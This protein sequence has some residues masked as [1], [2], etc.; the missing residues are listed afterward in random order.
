M[1]FVIVQVTLHFIVIGIY[2]YY[3]PVHISFLKLCHVR[4]LFSMACVV[5]CWFVLCVVVLLINS[6]SI[7]IMAAAEFLC[8]AVPF[9]LTVPSNNICHGCNFDS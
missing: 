7:S 6:I 2:S 8:C 3:R 1:Y 4:F 9:C 5:I